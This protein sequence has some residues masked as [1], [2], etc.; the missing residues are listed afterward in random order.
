MGFGREPQEVP[1]TT[2]VSF[3][4]IPLDSKRPL[5]RTDSAPGAR[6]RVSSNGDGSAGSPYGAGGHALR[7][8]LG[9][10]NSSWREAGLWFRHASGKKQK[11]ERAGN[12]G[13]WKKRKYHHWADVQW[14]SEFLILILSHH[15]ADGLTHLSSCCPWTADDM[16]VQNR[17]HGCCRSGL[18]GGC[19]RSLRFS[20]LLVNRK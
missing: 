17:V 10:R 12:P 9:A 2:T 3:A 11:T 14:P 16:K 4:E 13:I 1:T 7:W 20:E 6:P 15:R 5:F 8:V 18:A 19:C